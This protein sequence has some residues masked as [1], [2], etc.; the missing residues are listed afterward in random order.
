VSAPLK[1]V[2]PSQGGPQEAPHFVTYVRQLVRTNRVDH[3]MIGSRG[4]SGLKRYLGS[5]STRVV[6]EAPCTVTVVKVTRDESLGA[7]AA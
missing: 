6:A 7:E 1:L 5:V 4:A 3:I 2:P